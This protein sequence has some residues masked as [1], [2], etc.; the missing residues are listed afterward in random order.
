M[1]FTAVLSGALLRRFLRRLSKMLFGD[2]KA[3]VS[4]S[5]SRPPPNTTLAFSRF[6]NDVGGI[7]LCCRVSR[8]E[9]AQLH[10]Q[11]VPLDLQAGQLTFQSANGLPQLV[12]LPNQIAD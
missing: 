12:S 10:Q 7:V 9:P 1:M 5:Y 8:F 3:R 6:A 11:L 4:S 2:L